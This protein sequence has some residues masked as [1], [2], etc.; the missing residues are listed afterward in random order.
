MGKSAPAAPDYVGAAQAQGQANIATAQTQAVLNNP[1][2]IS[3]YGTQ[4]VTYG[5]AGGT[6]DQTGYQN[7]LNAWNA[8]QGQQVDGDG[9]PIG[10]PTPQPTLAQFT[11]GGTGQE[12]PTITQ[13]LTPAAQATLNSQQQVQ[14]AL[15]GLAQQGIGTA[16]NVL[17]T[18]FQYNGPQ[19]QTSLPSAGGVNYGPSPGQYGQAQGFDPSQYGQASGVGAGPSAQT[20]LDTSGIAQAPI[21]AGTTAYQAQMN[22][23]QP[24]I[25]QQQE[26]LTQQLQNQGIPI[27]STAY[28]NA[29]L[30]QGQ[31]IGALEDQAAV[32]GVGLQESANQQ[33]YNQ[34][35]GQAGLYNSGLAQNFGQQATAQQLGNSAIA[36][37]YGQG[38]T[39]Q[40]L[41]T[42]AVGQ[43]FGQIGA[44][45]SA[46]NA[47]IAQNAGLG[48]A[49]QQQAN[50]A[51]GQ[52]FGQ[53]ATSAQ[54]GNQA[55]AQNA[56][57]GLSGVQ[58]GNAA[59]GQNYGQGVTSAG[60]YNQGQ[61]QNYNENLGGAT[62]GNTAAQQAYQQQLSQY[63]QPLNEIAALMSGSQIQN[64]QFQSYS[65]GGNIAAAPI[66]Q[67]VTN[68]GN[69]NTA[70]YNSQQQGM[71]G[72]LG[73]LGTAAG[74]YL[75]S[76]GG[77]AALTSLL[78]LL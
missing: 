44:A 40:Q 34:A 13:T 38:L 68:Q 39:A 21:N 12:Q 9:N 6:V 70:A 35:L 67:A 43:N 73:G 27:G 30:S 49:G 56:G 22:L 37:N 60:L 29:M 1:N 11:S 41:Q 47:A 64:P 25:D 76:T 28:N 15:G 52:N 10:S 62:F 69:Y 46:Q 59:V 66:A 26:Q 51:V 14:Q 3:P 53:G 58:T 77:A 2:I 50:S 7:A 72:L 74:G 23:L 65:G 5:N 24:Q 16:Q 63:N 31:Q 20:G 32:Q 33:G 55:I 36:Q 75:G 48:L 18:P 71:A 19:I 4:T 61:S 78:G 54:L 45:N 42:P 17:G 8:N 57:L